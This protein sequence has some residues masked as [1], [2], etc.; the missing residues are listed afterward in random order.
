MA[1]SGSVDAEASKVMETSEDGLTGVIEMWAMGGEVVTWTV[2][3][4][5]SER[6]SSSVTRSRTSWAPSELN[7]RD[8]VGPVASSKAPSLSRSH[9]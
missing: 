4:A 8:A 3:T 5:M 9:S 1:S 7:E 2:T 6:S